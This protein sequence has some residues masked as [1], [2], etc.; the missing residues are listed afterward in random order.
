MNWIPAS[1]SS[2]SF[3]RARS[4]NVCEVMI[5][6]IPANWQHESMVFAPVEKFRTAGTLPMPPQTE[7]QHRQR[8]DIWQQNADPGLICS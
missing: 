5:C 6:L 2:S 7:Q 1:V 8:V 4:R 3:N